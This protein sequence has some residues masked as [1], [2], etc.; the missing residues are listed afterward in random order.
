MYVLNRIYLYVYIIYF[1]KSFLNVYPRSMITVNKLLIKYRTLAGRYDV[2]VCGQSP[3]TVKNN[4]D[5]K[6]RNEE[7][8]LAV[9]ITLAS[10]QRIA[11]C[12]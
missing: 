2:N 4:P 9:A 8:Y 1:I 12:V 10:F 6:V 3:Q 7:D 5:D 11:F